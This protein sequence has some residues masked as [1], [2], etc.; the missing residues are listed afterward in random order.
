MGG[1]NE[2]VKVLHRKKAGNESEK[3]TRIIDRRICFSYRI[4]YHH[5]PLSTIT[6]PVVNKFT[7]QELTAKSHVANR[8]F[9][10]GSRQGTTQRQL[11]YEADIGAIGDVLLHAIVYNDAKTADGYNFL[12][13]L[14]KIEPYLSELDFTMANQE[15]MPGGTEIGL[16]TYP[17]FNSPSQIIDNLQTV[18]IDLLSM[19]NN[20]SLDRGL[21]GLNSAI[22]HLKRVGMPYVG[23]YENEGDR[24]EKRIFD[25]NDILIGVLS[26]TYG[27]NG[28]P[29]PHGH[30]YAV[31]L[32]DREKVVADIK[33]M[34]EEVD[35]VV[36]HAHW[37]DEYARTPNHGQRSLAQEFVEAGADIIFGHHPHVIQPIERLKDR[38]GREAI[39]FYS[40]GNFLSGQQFEY[41]DIGGIGK[42]KVQKIVQG[43]DEQLKL[44]SPSILPTYVHHRNHTN[45][46][47]MLLEEAYEKGYIHKSADMMKQH[48]EKM[49]Q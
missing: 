46:Q 12:P 25:V 14:E 3:Q 26:Y 38:Y 4:V 32:L 42:V 48:T 30:E 33:G 21:N 29:I 34:R 36:V 7:S 49:M 5:V 22:S 18:G 35:I 41:K 37:G 8:A 20:H 27:T 45:Y 31:A 39:V 23:V 13:M 6:A 16:S 17:A 24:N 40:L 28:I 47:V 43:E 15:S 1:D 19:A 10:G 44:T 2:K 11:I 9:T